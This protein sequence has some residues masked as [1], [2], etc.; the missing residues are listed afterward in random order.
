MCA[1]LPQD[2]RHPPHPS[3]Q[4]PPRR[5]RRHRHSPGA[6]HPRRRHP[7]RRRRPRS[8]TPTAPRHAL[9]APIRRG[10]PGHRSDLDRNSNGIACEQ[11][12][13]SSTY[14]ARPGRSV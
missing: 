14:S 3:R 1:D 4:P 6:A 2:R 12:P 13:G 5:F 8:A 10:E 7:S 9:R 11:R